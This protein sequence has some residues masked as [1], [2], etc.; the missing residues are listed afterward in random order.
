MQALKEKVKALEKTVKLLEAK[1]VKYDTMIHKQIEGGHIR[2][3]KA[4]KCEKCFVFVKTS[5]RRPV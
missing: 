1:G 3:Q 5:M 4:R 2:S